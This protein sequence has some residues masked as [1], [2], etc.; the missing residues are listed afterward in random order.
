MSL[1]HSPGI[2]TNGLVFCYDMNNGK[3]YIGAPVTNLLPSPA[4]NGYPTFGNSWGTYNTNQYGSGTYWS[5]GSVASVSNN[6]VTMT[7][8]HSLRTY[9][10]MVPQTSGGG[11][12]AGTNYLI[13]KISDTQF[14]LYPYNGSQDGSQ[15]YINPVTG[16]H[17]VYDDMMFDNKIAIN[18]SGFP[19]MWWGA[20]HLPNSGLVK[21]IIKQGFNGIPGRPATDCIRLHYIRDAGLDG[22][23]YGADGIVTAGNPHIVS[24]W[25]R[26]VTTSAVGVTNAYQIYNHGVT[27]PYSPSWGFTLG[28]L[29]E[30]KKYSFTFTPNNPYCFSY[31]FPGTGNMKYDIACIQ[32]ETGSIASNFVAGTRSNTQAILDLVG[33][34]TVTASSLTYNSNGTFGFNGSSNYFDTGKDLSWNNLDKASLTFIL[35]PSNLTMG[36]SGFAGKMNPDWEWAFYQS[37]TNLSMVYW[38]TGGGHSNGMDWTAT[39]FFTSTSQ[40][41]VFQYVWDG[42]TS[43]VYRNGELF[44]TKT[45]TDPSINQNRSNNIVIG[46][47]TYVWGDSYWNGT[48]QVACF[49][50]RALTPA[51]VK[52]NFNALRGRYSI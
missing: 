41:V 8:A 48:I 46:G 1:N 2:V 47:H 51:E 24:F 4:T 19:T 43:Y 3:S 40:Y 35:K 36:N 45:A 6:I 5:I 52:Q 50:N 17:K 13:K 27:S 22:M 11:V 23:A 16:N 30:W 15:G 21:E 31:W 44:L 33:Q 20:P 37:G 26:A 18:A 9:D 25:A 49:Y 14:C 10:V 42:S 28:A 29:G 34:N 38:N 32:F 39:N 12:T 7:A